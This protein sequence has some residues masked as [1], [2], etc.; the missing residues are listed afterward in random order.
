MRTEMKS[1]K[2]K[3]YENMDMILIMIYCTIRRSSVL[4]ASTNWSQEKVQTGIVDFIGFQQ[5]VSSDDLSFV[6]VGYGL[7]L[8]K[9]PWLNEWQNFDRSHSLQNAH[10]WSPAGVGGRDASF[11]TSLRRAHTR[12]LLEACLTLVT[13]Q[14]ISVKGIS[15]FR[16]LRNA[17]KLL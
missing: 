3:I 17:P 15:E 10:L 8:K 4:P 14:S 6:D 2:R 16:W 9:I 11:T 5:L 13:T 7:T 12:V 1:M